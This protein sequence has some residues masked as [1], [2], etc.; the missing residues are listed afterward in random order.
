MES[1]T[2]I[3]KKLYVGFLLV[4][5]ATVV[6]SGLL[7][8]VL[9]RFLPQ[10]YIFI[11][12]GLLAIV[13]GMVLAFVMSKNLTT[14]IRSLAMT[15]GIVAEGD[16]TRD[17]PVN[18]SDEVGDLASAFNLMVGSLRDIVREVKT[19]SDAVTSS[20][21]ALS[22]SAEEMNASTEEI[23]STVEQIAKGAEHQAG[24]VEQTSKVMREMA[25]SINEIAARAKSA[26]E[27]AAE[28][29]YTAQTGGKSAREAMEKMKGVFSIIE[30]A[31][32]GV[33]GF[34]EKT[35]QIG[36]IVDVITKIAQ[37]THLLALN[38]TIE[39]A[40][41]GEAGRGFAV[42][43]EE[44]RKLATEAAGSAEKIAEIIKQIQGEN[45]KV[46]ASIEVA[47]REIT[48]GREVL[49][50][51][52]DALEDIVRVVVEEVKKV[53]EISALTQQQTQGAQELVKTIDEIAKVAEDNAA[54][55]EEASA[56]TTEQTASMEQM[57]QSAQQLSRLAD[58][59]KTLVARFNV[60][61]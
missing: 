44:V 38:A 54:S 7:S 19:T 2:T 56:A 33:K 13:A 6:L 23:A 22:A 37:Q 48:S 25:S 59:L 61:A 47:T 24:L 5:F 4:I 60:G 9:G 58:T 3:G 35:Q 43:A 21:M 40:R 11:I 57:A 10:E 27:A 29:G 1:A 34:S 18:T 15:A 39:A 12:T 51:T 36:T 42:V 28:A 32:T 46:V 30:S 49:T 53:Q 20:A 41:A 50:Y 55:T 16:L 31:A 14:E 45:S 26:A 17:V 52:G 8:W